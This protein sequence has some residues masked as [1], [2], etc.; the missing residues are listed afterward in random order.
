MTAMPWDL[1]SP[2]P[3]NATSPP[4]TRR[5]P[6]SGR[7]TPASILTIVD[8]PAPFSPTRAWA[9]PPYSGKLTPWT[10]ATAPNDFDT[11]WTSRRAGASATDH[12]PVLLPRG[13]FR[14]HRGVFE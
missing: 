11:S 3:A 1:A 7:C 4:S 12:L 8:L 14:I 6:V 5:A 10:A 13:L 2:G 9:S